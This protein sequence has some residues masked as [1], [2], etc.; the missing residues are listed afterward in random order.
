MC[1]LGVG[2][3]ARLEAAP[4]HSWLGC[5]GVCV[6]VCALRLYPATPG[7]G[8]RCGCVCLISGFGCVPP[9]LAGVLGVFVFVGALR[10]YPATPRWGVRCGCVCFGLGCGCTPPLLAGVFGCVCVCVRAPPVPCHSW[11][12][13]ALWVCV[14]GLGSRLRP[15]TPGWVVGVCVSVCSL[16]LYPTFPGWGLWFGGSVLPGTRSCAVVWCRLCALLGFAATDGLCCLAPV[17]VPWLWPAACLSGVPCGPA[18]VRRAS[19]GPVALGA[20]VSFPVAV[21]PFPITGVLLGGCAGHVEAGREPGS[22]CLPLAAE[23]VR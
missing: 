16:C 8:L 19:S 7:R 23:Q 20:L 10:V 6:F 22:L 21:V 2:T 5:W 17:R 15:A 4:R 12:G 18:L 14:L 1:D 9:L 11:L 3:W 13:C